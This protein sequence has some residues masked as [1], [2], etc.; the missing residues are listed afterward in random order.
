MSQGPAIDDLAARYRRRESRLRRWLRPP[1]PFLY[2]P[3][4][5]FLPATP[6][7]RLFIGGAG[8]AVPPG[9]LCLDLVVFPGVAVAADAHR[10]PF[11][12]LSIEAIE[13]DAVLEHVRD[14]RAVVAEFARILKPGGFIHI[15]VPFV[16]PYHAYPDDYHRWTMVGLRELLRDFVIVDAGVRT[17]PAAALAVSALEV[18]RMVAPRRLRGVAWTAAA[19]LI[20]PLRYLDRWLLA[21]PEAHVMANSLFILA[22]KAPD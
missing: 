13:C 21:S 20:W 1:A 5:S 7:P 14:P 18:V 19:W 11:A 2:N 3:R 16:H 6:M 8:G 17:G 12:N 15:V 22:R 4:E 10:M 9:F